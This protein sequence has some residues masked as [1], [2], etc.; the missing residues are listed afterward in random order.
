M[1]CSKHAV[2][3]LLEDQNDSFYSKECIKYVCYKS[4]VYLI[5][6]IQTGSLL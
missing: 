6:K 4:K 3:N 1:D 5:T 2:D